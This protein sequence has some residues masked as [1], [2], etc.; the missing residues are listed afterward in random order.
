[1]REALIQLSSLGFVDMRPHAEVRVARLTMQGM[2]DVF[3]VLAD[4]ESLAA[5]LA[6]RRLNDAERERILEE[7]AACAETV[8]SAE[9]SAFHEQN[10]RF[11]EAIH[12]A[13][14]NPFLE[15]TIQ[16]VRRRVA[17]YRRLRNRRRE[18]REQSWKEHERV[19]NAIVRGD[20]EQARQAMRAHI[21]MQGDVLQDFIATLPPEYFS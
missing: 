17:L 18:R 14:R 7:H 3:E 10:L 11:H 15:Q 21:L 13:S 20:G 5:E 12:A 6:A 19:V 9:P 1:V 16:S 2:L 4:L 8:T